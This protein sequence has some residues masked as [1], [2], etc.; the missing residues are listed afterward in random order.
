M[1]S[2]NR[3]SSMRRTVR[4]HPVTVATTAA[5][6]GVL[7]GGFVMV[8]LFAPPKPRPDVGSAQAAL[9]T[10][11]A[12]K[13]APETTGSAPAGESAASSDCDKQTWPN[14]SRVCMDEYRSKNRP[15]R[16]VSTD[17]LD[18]QSVTA[19]EAQPPT[20]DETKLAVPALWDPSVTSAATLA[21][22]AAPVVTASAP[23]EAAPS[24]PAVASPAPAAEPP[25]QAAA[26]AEPK[27]RHAKKSKAKK[28]RVRP[29][30]D[31]DTSV[32]NND[33]GD[34]RITDERR[35]RSPR[36][37]ERWTERDYDVPNE[38][39]RGRR[40]VTV[41]KRGGGGGLFENLFGMGGRGDDD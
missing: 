35:E 12:P 34:D 7:L 23:A 18:K 9:A 25:T 14:L 16:V 28:P 32:A 24:A 10:K 6:C 22:P 3:F 26:T 2:A 17:K 39:G 27:E 15:A 19:I 31:E 11:S 36:I 29:R 30:H 41:I 40:Q 4:N 38:N 21:T 13:P 37:V 8:E 20:A 1:P 33:D 5:A